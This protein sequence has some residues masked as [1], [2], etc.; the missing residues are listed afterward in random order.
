[1]EY[2][3]DSDSDL[4]QIID[5]IVGGGGGGDAVSKMMD[6]MNDLSLQVSSLTPLQ[7]LSHIPKHL[8]TSTPY[9]GCSSPLLKTVQ[10]NLLQKRVKQADIKASDAF[11]ISDVSF[12]MMEDD[13]KEKGDSRMSVVDDDEKFLK[14]P[15]MQDVD[16]GESFDEFDCLDNPCITPF[17]ERVKKKFI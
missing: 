3:D 16:I 13:N 1:M 9:A 4:S 6:K 17:A 2:M 12:M 10:H 11:D 14:G 15:T 5:D 7:S 8:Q